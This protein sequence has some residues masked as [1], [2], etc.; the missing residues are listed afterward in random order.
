VLLGTTTAQGDRYNVIK[1]LISPLVPLVC[2]PLCFGTIWCYQVRCF[3]VIFL[4]FWGVA[5]PFYLLQLQT[6]PKKKPLEKTRVF[7][8]RIRAK[9]G[10]VRL[11]WISARNVAEK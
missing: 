6:R 5:T 10:K 3:F 11:R 2:S 7:F 9:V 4:G 1:V 8:R